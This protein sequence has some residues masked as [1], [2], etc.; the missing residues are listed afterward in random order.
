MTE[1]KI[2]GHGDTV[3]TDRNERWQIEF[4][5]QNL[6]F[7]TVDELLKLEAVIGKEIARRGT[8]AA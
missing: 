4:V 5:K 7:L 1:F 6:D 2:A 3:F 8:H